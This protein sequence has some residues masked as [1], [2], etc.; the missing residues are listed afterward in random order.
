MT[1]AIAQGTAQF[2]GTSKHPASLC[3]IG[4]PVS[5]RGLEIRDVHQSELPGK[6][7]EEYQDFFS[8][9]CIARRSWAHSSRNHYF[10]APR[11]RT[12]DKGNAKL[13]DNSVVFSFWR[14]L[15]ICAPPAPRLPSREAAATSSPTSDS[16]QL[17]SCKRNFARTLGRGTPAPAPALRPREQLEVDNGRGPCRPRRERPVGLP[18]RVA[19]DRHELA[20]LPGC[21]E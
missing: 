15:D 5:S 3:A 1:C 8:M 17:R 19:A 6:G 9:I 7:L 2:L 14:Y 21:A 11:C 12:P 18:L 4:T 10:L 16:P 20:A 13:A